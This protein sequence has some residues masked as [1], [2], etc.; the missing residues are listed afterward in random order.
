VQLLK[1]S[2]YLKG[3]FIEEEALDTPANF[4]GVD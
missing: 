2:G 4:A 3:V 1:R